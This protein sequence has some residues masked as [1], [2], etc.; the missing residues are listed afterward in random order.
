MATDLNTALADGNYSGVSL[1]GGITIKE[2]SGRT[3]DNSS[4]SDSAE[5]TWILSGSSNPFTCRTALVDGPVP[6]NIHDGLYLRNLA[7]ENAGPESWRFTASYDSQTPNVGGYTVNVDTTGA[8]LTQTYSHAQTKF[9]A[10]GET[11]PDAG[12]AVDLQDGAPKGAERILPA[13][14]INV[15][16]KIATEYIGASPMAYAKVIAGLT[17]T[18]N[19]ASAFGGEFAAGELLFAGATGDIIST[20]P[21]LTFTF[22]ASKN[23]TGLTIGTITGIDKLGHDYISF[24][25]KPVKDPTTKLFTTAVRGAYVDRIYGP[26]DHTALS[27]GVAPT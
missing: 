7:Y 23:V 12:G 25:Y 24:S 8:R 1:Y 2:E 5:R 4:G 16:A 17:G 3:G 10:T 11:L 27:I 13:L 14:A 19:N 15:R 20:N 18:Y 6:I 21:Q 9:P 22:L 26:A